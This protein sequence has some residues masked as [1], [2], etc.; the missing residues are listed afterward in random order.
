M[1]RV[2]VVLILLIPLIYGCS[3]KQL[4][5]GID[6]ANFDKS[7]RPQ[8][9][10]FQYVNGTWLK[11]A[12]IPADRS[13]WGAFYVLR[14]EAQKNLRKIIEESANAENK[15]EGS[16]EQKVG[17]FYLS[18]MDSALI[19]ELG[20]NPIGKE[21]AAIKAIKTKDELVDLMAHFVRIGVQRPFTYWINQDRK[22]STKYIGYLHQSGLSLPD[23]DYYFNKNEKFVEIRN[24]FV[25]YVEDLFVLANINKAAKKA[26]RIMEMETAIAKAH[27][28]RVENRDR[29]KTYNKYEIVKLDKENP[30]FNWIRYFEG[31]GLG[32]E[33]EIIVRQPNYFKEFDKLFK[34][35]SVDD[36]KSYFTLKLV[37]ISAPY[38]S[39]NFVDLEFDF[40]SKTLRGVEKIRPRWKR[41]VSATNNSLGEIVGKVYVKKHF[42]PEAK[43][44][45]VELVENLRKSYKKRIEQVDWMSEE[46][47]KEA[48]D[49]LAKFRPKIGYPDKWKDYSKL[50]VKKDDLVGN[51]FLSNQVE[52]EREINKLGK[53]IDRDEWFM[54][55]QTVNAYYN[56]TMNEV[57]FP[58]AI[59]QPPFFN[60]DAD[61]AVNYGA[62]G[63]VIG[64]EMTH[65]FDDQG[66]KSDGDGNLREWWTEED[67]ERFTKRAQ[68]MIDQYNQYNPIDS[69]HVNGELTLG[70]NIA[71]LGGLT[72]AYYAYKMSLDGKVASVIDGFSGEQRFFLGN[73]QVWQSIYRDEALRQR[74]VTDPHSPAM[75]RC[76][77]VV[78]NMPEFYAAFDVKED[79]PMYRAEDI[80]VKIW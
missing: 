16:E 46:T 19:E 75:Y 25:K 36:W 59:L 20:I 13:S 48:L 53:P 27:W 32:S 80:R 3:E 67:N 40:Y 26:K 21:I 39:K 66:R 43:A 29:N 12:E 79:D 14:E 63:A 73:A 7:V 64:H 78:S 47:K 57:V 65:G 56:P 60:M 55:P 8:D 58:A 38:L 24:K 34:K 31:A 52:Y 22:E 2:L 54:S 69:M 18:Y 35:F 15:V 45:M 9:D 71:D 6:Q 17:D 42:K 77:G 11:N 41:A 72:I 30:N 37:D 33:K 68:V 70:E 23:R 61:D 50:V 76:N 4:K 44:R 62:I 51:V 28:T 10:F 74:L 1:F 5:S 49:K